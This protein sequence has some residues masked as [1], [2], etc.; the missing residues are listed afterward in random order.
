VPYTDDRPR[1]Y[2]EIH[3]AGEPILLITGFGLSCA[4]LRPLLRAAPGGV[5][6]IVYDHPGIGRSDRCGVAYTTGMLAG[7][8][9]RVLDRL[10]LRAA[11]IAGMS[12]G[13]AVAIELA[14]RSPERVGSL[15]LLGTTAA[16]P[17]GRHTD[18][19]A[20]ARVGA[21]VFTGSLSRRRLWFGP[22]LYSP[23]HIRRTA[24]AAAGPERGPGGHTTGA[25]MLALLGQTAAASLHD[26]GSAI[27]RITAPTLVMHGEADALLPVANARALARGIPGSTLVIVPGAG[28]AFE[29]ER[30]AEVTALLA[31]WAHRHPISP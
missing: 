22:A 11:H 25:S 23:D 30:P 17:L 3:G 2:Y 16:G 29:L 13:G 14:L 4:L 27:K 12:L 1:L 5:Q 9:L 6:F 31:D 19:V 15:A 7:A 8:A 26:R 24:G 18:A 28:H 21:R 10:G 20:L